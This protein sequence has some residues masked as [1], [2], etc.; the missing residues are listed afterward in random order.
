[1]QS[2]AIVSSKVFQSLF[3]QLVPVRLV[4]WLFKLCAPKARR[5]GRLRP[6]ELIM[7]LVFHVLAGAGT[8]AQHVKQITGKTIT[9]GALSQR[10]GHLPWQIF[11]SL[12]EEVLKPKADP[13]KHP[14]A[15]YQGL[16][17]C[18]VDGTLFSVAN[19]PQIKGVLPKATTRRFKAA[20]AKIGMVSLVELG[21]H[22]PISAAIGPLGESEMV[23]AYRL[24]GALPKMSLLIA[25]RYYGVPAYIEEFDRIHPEGDCQFLLRAKA[26]L[27]VKVLETFGDGSALVEISKGKYKRQVREVRARVRRGRKAWTDVRLWTSLLDW[28]KHPAQALLELYGRRWDHE[29]AYKELK[30]EMRSAPL[31]QS[32]TVN[33]A[34]QEIAALLIAYSILIDQRIQA[35][36][37]GKIDVLRISFLKTLHWVRG[38]WNFLEVGQGILTPEQVR[39]YV[40][41]TLKEISRATTAKR[42]KRSCPRAV[43][44]PVSSRP[45]LVKNTY[46]H[47]PVE[48]D[49]Q[50]MNTCLI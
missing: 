28:K 35:G 38:L 11:E 50:P 8:L 1:M 14:Q 22:N 39:K 5:P 43:R 13:Q 16:R 17:L 45:R 12:L 25:D 30:I 10:R 7:S 24:V 46:H 27:K 48:Y 36:E 9:D 37:T 2:Q 3:T 21:V 29:I 34:A 32:H 31:L 4:N 49:I 26:N 20:F 42:R 23:L 33:T 41:N 6:H 44:Q 19:T 47:G 15:F 18:G 40:A